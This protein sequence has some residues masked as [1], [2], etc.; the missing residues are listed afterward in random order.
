MLFWLQYM[1]VMITEAQFLVVIATLTNSQ[2]LMFML[3]GNVYSGTIQVSM[4]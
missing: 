2:C 4:N 1:L 3:M